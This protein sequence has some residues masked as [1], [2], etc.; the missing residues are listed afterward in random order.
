MK[1]MFVILA[2]L[3][4]LALPALAERAAGATPTPM[5][6][7]QSAP[8]DTLLYYNPDGG[9]KYHADPNCGSIAMRYRP[10]TGCVAYAQL[11]TA[12]YITLKPCAY[13]AAP[14]RPAT[15][16]VWVDGVLTEGYV[17]ETPI[18]MPA[19]DDYLPLD[20][21]VSTWGGDNF[22]TN[23]AAG[24]L[25][26]APGALDMVWRI[27]LPA[28]NGPLFAEEAMQPTIIQWAQ[29]LRVMLDIH[30]DMKATVALK[31]VF[32]PT[33]DGQILGLR[34]TDGAQTRSPICTGY[35][36]T[37][38]VTLHPL[39]YPTLI[40]GQA[41]AR[42]ARAI[43]HM[44][45]RYISAID[46]VTD[47]FVADKTSTAFTTSALIDRT[48]NT[49]VFLS[50]GG[51]LFTEQL[52]TQLYID[53][54]DQLDCYIF[55]PLASVCA[56][57][58]ETTVTA[59]PVMHENLL[60]LGNNAGQVICVDTTTMQPLW[61]TK[62]GAF[63]SA[64]AMRETAEGLQLLAVTG[65]G[66][67][68]L[69]CLDPA[70][71]AVTADLPLTLDVPGPCAAS[72]PVVGQA[73]L[74]G[75]VFVNLTGTSDAT[76][77]LSALYAIDMEIGQISWRVGYPDSAAL[78]TPVAVCDDAGNGFLIT[79]METEKSTTLLLLEGRTGVILSTLTIGG[80][81]ACNPAVFGDMLV[82][83]T[84]GESQSYVNGIRLAPGM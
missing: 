21:A 66:E 11:N 55:R 19:G 30:P 59:A 77:G 63:V 84:N 37:G 17:R 25:K 1:R 65:L 40:A 80:V 41:S 13:C 42:R 54:N 6:A 76:A 43:G 24:S 7:P 61:T 33:L 50:S 58:S 35:P 9:T 74:D 29:E 73:G 72:A 4:L 16:P 3:M 57:V 46:G 44:G 20:F 78:T 14:L 23:A 51:W 62:A 83:T 8:G 68:H 45:L 48:S 22:R 38:S 18:N 39:G 52:N 2:A 47:R 56:R 15:L 32:L 75:L 36:M 53:Q 67:A 69:V 10:M 60:F 5:P 28:D 70:T 82:I 31:E 64:L 81:D 12:P 26:E 34:L 71:G 27:A 49:A 79:A